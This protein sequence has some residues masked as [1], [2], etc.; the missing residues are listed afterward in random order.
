LE[1][2][3]K[4]QAN[5]KALALEVRAMGVDEAFISQLVDTF[6]VRVQS[7][8]ELGPVF[9]ERIGDRWPLHLAK[10][11]TFWE[12]IA[13]RT[14]LYEGKPMQTHKGIE[15]ARPEHFVIWLKLW[16]EVLGEIAPSE[17]ARDY[18]IEKA[19]S[20]GERLSEGRFGHSVELK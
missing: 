9:A 13:L 8:P 11:K 5:R 7:H 20:M 16:E 18:L 6:Y 12:S 19:R 2:Y 1:A 17:E 15:S 14:A 10:M 4:A 3:K